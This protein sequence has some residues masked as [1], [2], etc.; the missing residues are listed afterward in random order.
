MDSPQRRAAKVHLIAGMLR[1]FS[2]QEAAAQAGLQI[3]QATAYRLLSRFRT[4]GAAG[5]EDGRH[6]HRFKLREPVRQWLAKY[7]RASPACTSRIVQEALFERFG[8]WVSITHLNR[9]RTALGV[10]RHPQGAG[11]KSGPASV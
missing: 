5:L 10:S 7:C 1:G 6:G 8:V 2:W 9:V 11:E 4:E 3:S